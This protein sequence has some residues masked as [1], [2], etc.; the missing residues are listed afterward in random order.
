MCLSGSTTY[1]SPCVAGMPDQQVVK[2]G[3][4]QLWRSGTRARTIVAHGLSMY[5][6]IREG[7]ILTVLPPAGDRKIALGDIVLFERADTI[8]AH[9]IVGRFRRDADLWFREKGDNM[10]AGGCFPAS[11]LIGRVVKIE[12]DGHV[13][14]LSMLWQRFFGR[15]A[16]L[17]WC[18]LFAIWRYAGMLKRA[19][20]GSSEFP[21]LRAFVLRV[22]RMLGRLP[23]C[24]FKQ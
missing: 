19:V 12:R 11:A 14:D 10:F 24:F 22:F 20:A 13:C 6:L 18:V 4:V 3:C 5:P 7:C 2:N 17:Y 9:R 1:I 21:R 15:A 16:G 8:V 23:A